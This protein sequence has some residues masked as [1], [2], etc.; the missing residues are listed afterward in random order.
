[1]DAVRT[2]GTTQQLVLAGLVTVV[3]IALTVIGQAGHGHTGEIIG[4]LK[5]IGAGILT[6]GGAWVGA[7]LARRGFFGPQSSTSVN[8]SGEAK[9]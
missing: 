8:G 7:G 2:P 4:L 3:G 5:G 6:V 1:M 9:H